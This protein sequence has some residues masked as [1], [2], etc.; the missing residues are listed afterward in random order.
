MLTA[1]WASVLLSI[2][3]LLSVGL[4]IVFS[5]ERYFPFYPAIDTEFSAD[6]SWD[7]WNKIRPGMHRQEVFQ[8]LGEP[9]RGKDTNFDNEFV[10]PGLVWEYS[11]DNAFCCWDFA[12]IATEVWFDGDFVKEKKRRIYNN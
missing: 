12:W 2:T 5:T 1:R 3:L 10:K 7:T 11:K 8:L 4:F 6:F 9:F